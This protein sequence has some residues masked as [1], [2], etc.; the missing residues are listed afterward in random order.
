MKKIKRTFQV[1]TTSLVVG[2]ALIYFSSAWS[3]VYNFNGQWQSIGPND[4]PESKSQSAGG[5][6]PIEF[7]R[8]SNNNPQLMLAGSLKGGLFMSENGGD[9]WQNAGSDNWRVSNC[10]WAEIHPKDDNMWFAV[11]MRDGFKG[12]PGDIGKNGGILR[13]KNR[14]VTWESVANYNDFENSLRTIIY[15]LRFHPTNP[16]KMYA[17]T[18]KGLYFTE[19]CTDDYL[20]WTKV[21]YVTGKVYDLEITNAYLCF[22]LEQK[23]SWKV[24]VSEGQKLL[25]IPEI[26]NEK[27]PIN[28]ITVQKN[29]NKFYFLIDFKTVKDEVWEYDPVTKNIKIVYKQGM[30]TFGAGYTFGINPHK[31][32]EL[33]IGNSVRIRKWLIK[34]QNYTSIDNEYHVDVECVEFHPTDS[35]VVFIGSHGG[36]FKTIDNGKSWLFKS[37]GIGNAEVHGLSVSNMDSQTMVVGLNHNGSLVRTDWQNN[38]VYYW[39][40]VNGG[41]ALIPIINP[42][43]DSII[44]TS[45]QYNGGGLYFSTDTAKHNQLLHSNNKLFTSGWS[46]AAK[47]HP[48]QDSVLFFNFKR[49]KGPSKGNVDVVRS[50]RPHNRDS[51]EVISN[52]S[53]SHQLKSYQVYG[54][55]NSQFHPNLLFAYV[56][57]DEKIGRKT[58]KLHKLF[59]IKNSLAIADSLI[60][61]W[62]E[63][64]VPR[65]G[66]IGDLE[67]HPKRWNK[68]YVSYVA[69]VK[70]R[71][72]SPDDKGMV[73]HVKYKKSD[74]TLV[75]NW[76]ISANIPSAT[77]GKHNIIVTKNKEMFIGTSTGIYY[78]NKSTLRGGKTWQEV[79]MNTPSCKVMGLDYKS[80]GI[81]TVGYDGRGVW[82]INVIPK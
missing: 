73:Y 3:Q 21:K 65:N 10:G 34:E 80:E 31:S 61:Q 59:M 11:S 28:K 25:P 12:A 64:E 45:N 18:T 32:N 29:N 77:G 66:W 13:T 70:V 54:I 23:K 72:S 82:Q 22:S 15:G 57:S 24:V 20:K 6:G 49:R 71:S 74:Y 17:L 7:I 68:M 44:Y 75:R 42:V 50:V 58:K 27:R 41:D 56:I 63:I 2:I 4:N 14:G 39:K 47:L 76:D 60:N 38:G 1:A 19:D 43:A 69:G 48:V 55:F 5:I 81:L 52:F 51:T 30:V 9:G 62:Q 67:L 33:W 40:Q 36:V 78:G 79:G 26:T 35:N 16:K 53:Q 37:K 46:M 8:I